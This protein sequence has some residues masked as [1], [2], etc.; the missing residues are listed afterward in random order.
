MRRN[1][2]HSRAGGLVDVLHYAIDERGHSQAELADIQKINAS[3]KIPADL[4][5]QPY[6]IPQ[7]QLEATAS[8]DTLTRFEREDELRSALSKHCSVYL[9]LPA[10]TLSTGAVVDPECA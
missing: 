2:G 4:L 9:K 7:P 6:R 8:T 1:A 5:V 3:W 10:S